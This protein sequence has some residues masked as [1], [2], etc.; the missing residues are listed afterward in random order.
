MPTASGLQVSLVRGGDDY[1]PK[2]AL[3]LYEL[4]DSD[5]DHLS[6][7]VWASTITFGGVLK[8]L[9][10]PLIR[11][12]RVNRKHV[13]G[14]LEFREQPD[15]WYQIGY[16]V[17]KPYAG[18]GVAKAALSLAMTMGFLDQHF[19][20]C[21]RQTNLK[22]RAVLESAGFSIYESVEGWHRLTRV[23]GRP[24]GQAPSLPRPQAWD[25]WSLK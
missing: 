2:I 3:E 23:I 4:I 7:L 25:A 19:F 24:R 21:V 22:S 17:G 6:N 9:N 18:M 11:V 14:C 5:R 16:W 20:A 1:D 12:I 8:H 10:K 13:A 15:G